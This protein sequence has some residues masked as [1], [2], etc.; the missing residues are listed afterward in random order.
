M[1]FDGDPSE[2]ASLFI[3]MAQSEW[4]SRI[5]YGVVDGLSEDDID[6]YAKLATQMFLR[7]VAPNGKKSAR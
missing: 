7:A 3:S 5:S 4:P 2:M 6:R 1:A